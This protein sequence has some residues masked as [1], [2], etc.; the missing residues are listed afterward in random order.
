[1]DARFDPD[2]FVRDKTQPYTF[3]PFGGGVRLCLGMALAKM[4]LKCFLA[5]LVREYDCKVANH[6]NHIFPIYFVSPDIQLKPLS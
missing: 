1:M 5:Y 3:V 4:E 2:R 6:N